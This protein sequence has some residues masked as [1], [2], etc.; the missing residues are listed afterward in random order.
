MTERRFVLD[1]LLD[2]WPDAV[3][4]DGTPVASFCDEVDDQD[5]ER[6]IDESGFHP[7]TAL[8]VFVI[9]NVAAALIWLVISWI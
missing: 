2:V 4:P 6:F 7:W 1:P 9:F 8:A 3:L 5:V